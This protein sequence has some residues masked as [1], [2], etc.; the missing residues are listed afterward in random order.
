M[1]DTI[2][3][4]GTN[5]V[6]FPAWVREF[7]EKRNGDQGL[8]M[9]LGI[10][11]A[12]AGT[13]SMVLFFHGTLHVLNTIG[14][15]IPLFLALFGRAPQAFLLDRAWPLG[16]P[17]LVQDALWGGLW[18]ILIGLALRRPGQ[19][20]ALL[21]GTV[22]GA[23]VLT[24]ISMVILPELRGYYPFGVDQRQLWWRTALLYA[25]WGW[26]TSAMLLLLPRRGRK[27]HGDVEA[28]M[29]RHYEMP[30]RKVHAG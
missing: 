12:V 28:L 7:H 5:P 22:M 6:E 27:R 8:M 23:V 11:G 16:L 26:G 1:S 10:A 29:G 14:D 20:P 3:R 18:G 4:I 30:R 21:L 19:A 24:T 2:H 25:A 9:R 13:L 17:M 15:D